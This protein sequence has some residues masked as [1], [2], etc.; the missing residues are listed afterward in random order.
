M[1]VSCKVNHKLRY[2]AFD[3][4]LSAEYA[5]LKTDVLGNIDIILNHVDLLIH[6]KVFPVRQVD[7]FN[8]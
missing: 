7:L 6:G 8:I 5:F 1:L 2:D 4:F 3:I